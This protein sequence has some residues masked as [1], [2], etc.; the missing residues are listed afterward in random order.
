MLDTD[1]LMFQV[2]TAAPNN[3]SISSGFNVATDNP[4]TRVVPERNPA[5]PV[6]LAAD[7]NTWE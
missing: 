3:I 7:T 4:L 5:A 6:A 2:E 1:F